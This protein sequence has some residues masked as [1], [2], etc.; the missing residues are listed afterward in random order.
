MEKGYKKLFVWHKVE[1]LLEFCC[2]LN[3]I[4]EDSYKRLE[5][6]RKNVGGLL[7][8]FYKSP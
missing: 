7:W 4:K 5:N 6:L 8:N 2:H 3:Y 1:Y